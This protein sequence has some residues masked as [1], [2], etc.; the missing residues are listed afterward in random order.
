MLAGTAKRLRVSWDEYQGGMRQ[1]QSETISVDIRPGWKAGTKMSYAGK[2]TAGATAWGTL[3]FL[4]LSP[5]ADT[6]A[7]RL[8]LPDWEYTCRLPS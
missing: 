4:L 1:Q 5:G 2:G 8:S 3:Y 6:P 7:V